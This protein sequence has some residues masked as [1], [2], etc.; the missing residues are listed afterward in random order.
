MPTPCTL[1]RVNNEAG[2][3]FLRKIGRPGETRT[4]D[5]CH[6]VNPPS[7][8]CLKNLY[9]SWKGFPGLCILLPSLPPLS[10]YKKHL[11]IWKSVSSSS[12]LAIAILYDSS[13]HSSG[14]AIHIPQ[15]ELTRHY[16]KLCSI[17]RLELLSNVAPTEDGRSSFG[18]N[19]GRTGGRPTIWLTYGSQ[20]RSFVS[21]TEPLEGKHCADFS[22][23]RAIHRISPY[24]D[25]PNC[26]S[27][28][29]TL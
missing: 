5:S 13:F 19:I 12:Q 8:F 9:T 20:Y 23:C 24:I 7:L 2:I 28:H 16:R 27:N 26:D 17:P 25:D 1:P 11:T 6:I 14:Y 18:G 3:R 10:L 22:R 15:L 4:Y 29:I 21:L